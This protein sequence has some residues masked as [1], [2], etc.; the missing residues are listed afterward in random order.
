MTK[1]GSYA[2]AAAGACRKHYLLRACAAS[3]LSFLAGYLLMAATQTIWLLLPATLVR[4]C[5]SSVVWIYS[6]L[7]I[8]QRIPNRLQ[9][10]AMALEMAAYVV[11]CLHPACRS[12][13]TPD[14]APCRELLKQVHALC[15]HGC[16]CW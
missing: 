9:G 11:R 4:S 15:E 3:F 10:R 6:T 7:L 1:T 5:G 12:C 8:Q 13:T 16:G 14:V 2:A